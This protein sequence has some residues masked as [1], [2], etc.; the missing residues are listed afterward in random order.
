[1]HTNLL[2]L[3]A[4]PLLLFAAPSLPA[5]AQNAPSK[6][7]A[8][9]RNRPMNPPTPPT[10]P[11]ANNSSAARE[12]AAGPV[13]CTFVD[14][15]LRYL[16]VGDREIVRRVYFAVRDRRWGTVLPRF[17]RISVQQ[18][19]QNN[20][21]GF[22]IDLAAV[23]KNEAS[24]VDY[25]W[26]GRIEGKGDGTITFRATGKANADF[27]SNRIGLC[28][29]YGAPALV[30]QKFE[31]ESAA[32]KTTAYTFPAFVSAALV[33]PDF[34]TLRYTTGDNLTVATTTVGARV[35]ME[36]QR[37]YGDSSFKAYAPLP[38]AYPA[39][40]ASDP[41][42]EETVTIRVTN[43]AAAA[44]PSQ[45][46]TSASVTLG[47][48]VPG[49]RVP[50]IAVSP[51]AGL[52][53][54]IF[55]AVNGSVDRN[56]NAPALTWG[57]N[58]QIHLFDDDTI[59]ENRTVIVDQVKSARAY[60]PNAVIRIAPIHAGPSRRSGDAPRDPRDDSAFGAAW[61]ASVIKYLALAGVAEAQFD[62]GAFP[63]QVLSRLALLAGRPVYDVRVSQPDPDR[64]AA[65]DAFAV[66]NNGAP[67]LVLVNLSARP[68]T[69]S[70]H[71]LAQKTRGGATVVVEERRL[72]VPGGNPAARGY[73]DTP[74]VTASVPLSASGDLRVVL[75][76]FEVC[77]V[78]RAAAT[79]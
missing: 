13:R 76:P 10:P 33:S 61:A 72:I 11:A 56:R 64:G 46:A 26:T 71:G 30:G 57:F 12:L 28:V 36:D 1:M 8:Q 59:R 21:S 20:K 69:V 43:G 58:P 32:G 40:P 62:M 22:T 37:T 5:A 29:L 70:C 35:D 60:A 79:P 44:A 16:H 52:P 48:L 45:T 65:V 63:T 49:A 7:T 47:A 17:T 3:L 39:V 50:K 66:D 25:Q 38:Y 67:V 24:G 53:D 34:Q 4:A 55:G 54:T 2:T 41:E 19:A 77:E 51:E 6:S 68:Q 31:T 15:E 42:R 9:T 78:R 23:C 27:Q 73:F 18:S 74:P 75:D 14:G